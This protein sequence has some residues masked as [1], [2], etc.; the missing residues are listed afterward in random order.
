MEEREEIIILDEKSLEDKIYMIRGQQVMLDFDLAKIYG[1]TVSAF[2][3]QVKRN[4][5]RFPADFM[6]QLEPSE[7]TQCSKSQNVILNIDGNKRGKNTKKMP[8]ACNESGIYML[9]TVL[10]GELAI[11]QSKNLI[12]IF[13]SMKDYIL[14][15]Q[16]LMITRK[17]Y[18]QLADEVRNNSF[19]IKEIKN[20]MVKKTELSV[21]M[22]L[23]DSGIEQKEILIFDGEPFKAD[24]VYQKIYGRAKRKIVVIDDYI[25][26]KTLQHLA[27][28]NANINVNVISD[29]KGGKPLRITEYQDFQAEF[30]TRNIIFTKTAGKVHDRYIVLDHGTKEMKVFHCGASSK[31]A[32]NSITTITRIQDLTGY[33]EMLSGLLCNPTLVLK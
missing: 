11:E 7:F 15:N 33:K 2:N 9:M 17:D 1:Y 20:T 32:E 23:F 30:G 4:I 27:H 29:N 3:Q 14:E 19:E 8:Y 26:S 13:K 25:S 16:Q 5:E 6:F 24:I 31:D 12:R 21:F 22:K 18:L 10:K 28:S